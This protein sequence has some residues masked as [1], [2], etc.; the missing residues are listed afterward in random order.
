MNPKIRLP[1]TTG[2]TCYLCR[3]VRPKCD[4]QGIR[5]PDPCLGK[6]PGVVN[7]CCGHGLQ[8][9]YVIFENG[10][11]LLFDVRHAFQAIGPRRFDPHSADAFVAHTGK[12]IGRAPLAAPKKRAK[13]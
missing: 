2:E 4:S 6:L 3:R 10:K 7:A 5:G 8:P 1:W 12:R 9:G 11:T 13:P